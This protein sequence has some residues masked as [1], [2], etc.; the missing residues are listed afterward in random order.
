MIDEKVNILKAF[1]NNFHINIIKG[2][3]FLKAFSYV[4]F[5][6]YHSSK[7]TKKLIA[8]TLQKH[9]MCQILHDI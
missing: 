9:H 6:N 1:E 5:F 4:I 3:L 7:I 8:I 2:K